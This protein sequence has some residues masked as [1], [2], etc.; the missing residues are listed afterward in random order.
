MSNERYGQ[1][2]NFILQCYGI[3]FP[4]IK[5]DIAHFVFHDHLQGGKDSPS[6][7]SLTVLLSVVHLSASCSFCLSSCMFGFLSVFC[8]NIIISNFSKQKKLSVDEKLN[9]YQILKNSRHLRSTGVLL[10]EQSLAL[11]NDQSCQYYKG[12]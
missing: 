11:K 1:N 6:V 10:F 12:D 8:K 5:R 4:P 3:D 7:I 9:F 2:K